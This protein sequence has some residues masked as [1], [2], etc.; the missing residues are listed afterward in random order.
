MP[1]TRLTFGDVLRDHRRSYP[2]RVALVDGDTRLT[3]PE[4]DDRVNRLA[5]AL[6]GAG[7]IGRAHV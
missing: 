5:N 4:L 3:W 6:R 7:E 1:A 2:D